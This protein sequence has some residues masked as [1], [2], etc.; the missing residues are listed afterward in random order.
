M[1]LNN[2][3]LKIFEEVSINLEVCLDDIQIVSRSLASTY[4]NKLIRKGFIEKKGRKFILS[5]NRFVRILANILID[6]PTMIEI[7]ANEGI[8]ILAHLVNKPGLSA[9][10]LAK[11]VGLSESSI[12][13]YLRNFLRKQILRKDKDRYFF[14]K[15]IWENLYQFI[16][17]YMNYYILEQFKKVPKNARIYY[18][19]PYEIIFSLA[20]EFSD[21]QKTAFSVFDKYGIKLREREYFYRF[22]Q[23]P[24]KKISIQTIFLDSLKIAGSSGLESS[25]RRLHCYLFYRK[26]RKFLKK[27]KHPDLDKL[28]QIVEQKGKIKYDKFPNYEEIV[29][30]GEDYDIR[31]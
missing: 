28:K 5:S 13:P 20:V 22:D 17:L 7:L 14:N 9:P 25:R 4:L 10:E 3:E 1:K 15:E 23:L 19:S 21:A 2:T 11:E 31:I 24:K 18:E 29:Q 16:S 6:D 8:S 12:Y 27:V 30:K 26:N